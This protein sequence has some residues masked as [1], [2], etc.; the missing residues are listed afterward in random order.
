MQCVCHVSMVILHTFSWLVLLMGDGI[1]VGIHH[2]HPY[3]LDVKYG[4]VF[5]SFGDP[6]VLECIHQFLV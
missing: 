2:G 3:P 5:G 1:A 4:Q 6:F